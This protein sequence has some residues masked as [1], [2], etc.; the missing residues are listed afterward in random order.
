MVIGVDQRLTKP[1]DGTG[2]AKIPCENFITKKVGDTLYV[3]VH[4]PMDKD[5]RFS[6]AAGIA[7]VIR[8]ME[9]T[10]WVIG[11]DFNSFPDDGGFHQMDETNHVLN[12][13]SVS[14]NATAVSNGKLAMKSFKP[15]PYD[16]VDPD[17]LDLH[18][19]LD[20]IL[21]HGF[22]V[23]HDDD[24]KLK[25]VVDDTEIKGKNWHP[26]DHFPVIVGLNV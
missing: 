2:S 12:T 1:G 13:R 22:R 7:E 11:G 18:G 8:E 10:R 26:S 20:H 24:D 5:E 21:V 17:A 23:E 14:D 3:C 25:C 15:Y 6:V 16:F 9:V 4:A 19:K